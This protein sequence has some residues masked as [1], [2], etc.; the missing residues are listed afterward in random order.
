MK[1][2]SADTDL[3]GERVAVDPQHVDPPT[4]TRWPAAGSSLVTY[5]TLTSR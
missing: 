4:A 1:G 3:G 2:G 5:E